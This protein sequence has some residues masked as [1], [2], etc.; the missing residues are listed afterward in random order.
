M[1]NSHINVE[2][3]S[4]VKPAGAV[5]T[6]VSMTASEAFERLVRYRKRCRIVLRTPLH[7]PGATARIFCPERLESPG[8]NEEPKFTD[9]SPA[10]EA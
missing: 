4:S 6:I 7:V 9:E 8:A 2:S 3:S 5:L 1:V 10:N